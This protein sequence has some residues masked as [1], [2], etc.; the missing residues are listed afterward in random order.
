MISLQSGSNGNC[1]YVET[2]RTKLL[3]DAGISPSL[4]SRRLA[5]YGLDMRDVDALIISHDHGDHVRYAGTFHRR[6]DIP[7]YIT[8]RTLFKALTNHGIGRVSDAIYFSVGDEIV[9]NNLSILTIPSPHDCADGSLFVISS[10]GKRLGIFT[11]LGHVFTELQS[12][13]KT[14]DAVFIESNYDSE[15]L[16]GGTYPNYLK[17]RI[18]GPEGHLS[19]S[20]SA[21]LLLA[22]QHLRWACLAHLSKNNNSPVTALRT[23]R[24]V[25]GVDL[26][27]YIAG[28]DDV[29][30]VLVI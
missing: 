7:L 15:M 21:E 5:L 1:L 4:A 17:Q 6:Y 2:G 28:R 3:V 18:Q 11:D 30:Q 8:R 13:M 20:E 29:S 19:N 16:M 12:L 27:L 24:E 22:G 9:M 25:I 23:H 26:Q 14:L 10:E